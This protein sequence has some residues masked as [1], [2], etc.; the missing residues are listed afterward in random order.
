MVVR[1]ELLGAVEGSDAL[2]TED[3]RREV[4]EIRN[5]VDL[6]E[7]A[8][9]NGY[10][11]VSMNAG[12]EPPL[13]ATPVNAGEGELKYTNGDTYKGEIV[14]NLRHG[15][16]RHLC[17]TGDYYDGSWR[18]DKREGHGSMVFASKLRYEGDWKD[19]KAHGHGVC[20]YPNGQRYEGEWEKDQKWGWGKLE[21]PVAEGEANVKW[22]SYEGEWSNNAMD[23]R[24]RYTFV[25]GSYYEGEYKQGQRTKGKFVSS[26]ESIEYTGGWKDNM[27]H[28]FGTFFQNGV[29]KYFGEWRKDLK[30]GRGKCEYSDGVAYDGDWVGDK[31]QGTG[32]WTFGGEKYEGG[33]GDNKREGDGT[34]TYDDGS[35]Y[36]GA[37]KDGKRHG[38]GKHLFSNGDLYE[39]DWKDDE[40]D[41]KGACKYHNGD[42]Y[43]GEWKANRRE[44][45]GVC[46]FQDGTKY[47]GEWVGDKWVQS[48]ADPEFTKVFGPGLAQG[49]AGAK[50]VFG[51][52][53]YDEDQ[54]K[55]LCG[56]D[57]FCCTLEGPA[58]VH[59][60]VVDHGDGTYAIQYTAELSGDYELFITIGDDELV[61]SSP[62]Q[63]KIL[64]G[65]PC[66]KRCTVSGSGLRSARA[67]VVSEFYVEARDE[68]K[69]LC[70]GSA[71]DMKL[72]VSITSAAGAIE[73][74][75]EPRQ[76]GT[77]RCSYTPVQIGFYRIEISSG[78]DLIGSSPYSLEVEVSSREKAEEPVPD[79][80]AKWGSIAQAEY[81]ADGDSDGWDSEPEEKETAEE[82][83]VREHPDV[84]VVDNLED[85]WKVGRYQAEKKALERKEKERRLA[86]LRQRLEKKY[87]NNV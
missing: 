57:A 64:P 3:L 79:V 17:S 59:A 42:R 53:A 50:T 51:I 24:G 1:T 22:E 68:H 23:G 58:E 21:I 13:G 26:D 15:K 74:D 49:T 4:E 34:C 43:Q 80:I 18:F 7:H 19:D 27:R 56:G 54:N 8:R 87:K 65:K 2:S 39:G 12:E 25:D 6:R 82:K 9:E 45:H 44:G 14:N 29:Q 32:K 66:P 37:W 84:A 11:I 85:M 63:V 38:K 48:S 69:N 60:D 10:Q 71:P 81:A 46:V 36:Q 33:F 73:A 75:V 28:G 62:Y 47:R 5:E 20:Y 67:G 41:G 35:R 76:D 70:V 83:Y 16:G 31:M 86:E 30:H 77:F 52:Q 61:G 72:G 40:R 55:R 78:R